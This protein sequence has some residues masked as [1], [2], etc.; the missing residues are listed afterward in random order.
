VSD[1]ALAARLQRLED[2]RDI[3]RLIASYGP[4]VDAGDPDATARLWAADGVYDVDGRRMES[5]ADV[6][7]MVASAAHQNLVA[8]GCCH[9]LGPCVVTAAGDSAVAVCESLVLVRDGDGYRVWRA[10][11]NHF[12]L[13]RGDSG[14]QIT[15]RTSRLL[16]G[17]PH[18]HALLT[19]GLGGNPA[20]PESD[21]G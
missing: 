15:A 7:A 12:A 17:S 1:D 10:T 8:G 19:S 18:A 2:E 20:L 16:D 14:W 6:R 3:A 21:A 13:E 4:A 11:A 9:F 5:R